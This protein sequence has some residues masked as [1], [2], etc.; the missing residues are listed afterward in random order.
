LALN[1]NPWAK[2]QTYGATSDPPPPSSFR[3]IPTLRKSTH[4]TVS[5]QTHW[6]VCDQQSCR[7]AVVGFASGFRLVLCT[8][9]QA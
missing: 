3:T 6:R 5:A 1:F 4:W 9:K 2:F 8:N 7:P